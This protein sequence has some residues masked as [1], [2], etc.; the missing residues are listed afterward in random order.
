[1][2]IALPAVSPTATRLP[3]GPLPSTAEL[4]VLVVD[5]EDAVR[6]VLVDMLEAHGH[7]VVSAAC[8]A[9]G[10]EKLAEVPYDVL[11]TDLSMPEMDG[12]ALAREVKKRRPGIKVVLVTGYAGTLDPD[13]EVFSYVDAVLGKPFDFD[14]VGETLRAVVE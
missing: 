13:A 10:L 6:D 5:D 3:S 2:T 9:E 11:F 1:M 8:G 12:R 4:R 7:S 14:K